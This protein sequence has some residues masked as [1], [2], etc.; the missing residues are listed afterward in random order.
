MSPA[1]P[2]RWWHRAACAGRDPTWWSAEERTKWPA[3]VRLCLACP[4]RQSCLDEAV[5]QR[6]NGVIR[7]GMLLV[8][9]SRGYAVVPLICAHCGLRPV[10]FNRT[11]GLPRYCGRACQR[12]SHRGR[13]RPV[14]AGGATPVGP[15]TAVG[16]VPLRAVG[17]RTPR[18]SPPAA[19]P[20][21]R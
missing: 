14:P 12:S 20:S 19:P 15:A 7:G 8:S 4:V 17:S 3:A 11:G 2:D 9:T 1:E 18:W 21:R 6:D 16:R 5:R 13:S 10:R